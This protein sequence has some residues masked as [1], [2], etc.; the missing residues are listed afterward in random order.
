MV[1]SSSAQAFKLTPIVQEFGFSKKQRTKSFRVVNTNKE[2]IKIEVAS[3]TREVNNKGEE[4][5]N[6]TEDF[7]VYPPL[8]EVPAGKSQVIRVSYIGDEPEKEVP[9][10]LIVRQI[11]PEGSDK[12]QL[13]VV[14]E[15]VASMYV[16]PKNVKAKLEVEKAFVLNGQLNMTLFNSGS[17]HVLLSKFDLKVKQG[18]KSSRFNLKE[19][20]YSK[21]GSVNMLSGIKRSIEMRVPAGS[22]SDGKVSLELIKD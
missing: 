8:F 14:L 18:K 11:P 12:N 22:F 3:Y 17:K 16:A 1:L 5:R 2:N 9:Y 20:K 10:R 21:I 15:Y 7:M 19:K 13:T 4:I 6:A